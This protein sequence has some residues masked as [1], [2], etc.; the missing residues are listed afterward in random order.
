MSPRVLPASVLMPE[1][2]A[3][4]REG[5][6]LPL[7]VSGTSMT[8]F[9]QPGRDV[10]YLKAPNRPLQPG[11]I[12]FF[13][14]RDGSHVLHRVWRAEPGKYWFLGDAQDMAEG[15]LPAQCVFA[16]VTRIE[17]NGVSVGPEDR[18][19]RFFA[20][21]WRYTR[22]ARRRFWLRVWRIPGKARRILKKEK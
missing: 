21:P 17:R 20:G 22:G 7:V 18:V 16:Y 8:P 4:L 6:E 15:P 1:Y 10:V 13:H 14:R 2:E 9:L 12:A 19:W 11:E 5:A 3:L